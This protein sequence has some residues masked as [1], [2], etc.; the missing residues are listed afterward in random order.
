MRKKKPKKGVRT[1]VFF[2][3]GKDISEVP[4]LFAEFLTL[5]DSS[6]SIVNGLKK[7]ERSMLLSRT[8]T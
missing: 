4:G 5:Q 2:Y 3:L 6:A 7:Y 1:T 8:S